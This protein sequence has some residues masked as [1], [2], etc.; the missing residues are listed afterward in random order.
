MT[1]K[2][3][4]SFNKNNARPSSRTRGALVVPPAFAVRQGMLRRPQHAITGVPGP[5]T[6]R[7]C[8]LLQG[9]VANWR[10]PGGG[11]FA[12]RSTAPHQ[13]A[14]L[15]KTGDSYSS[16]RTTLKYGLIIQN[17]WGACQ[18]RG[19]IQS[20]FL[21]KMRNVNVIFGKPYL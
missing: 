6:K 1:T 19:P 8:A 18:G 17:G 11:D 16:P 4:Q 13:P 10:S 2:L 21:T 12:A 3:K 9:R 15:W 14:A 5:F 20:Y 7:I